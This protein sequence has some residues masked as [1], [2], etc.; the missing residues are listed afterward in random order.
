MSSLKDD[1]SLILI[2][3][4]YKDGR[5]D[6]VKPLGNSIVHPDATGNHDGTDGSTP[7]E[8]NFTF[9]RGS[10][11]AAT[12]VDVNGL[13]EKG[14]E[15]LLL[16]SNQFD[17]TWVLINAPTLTSGQA[18]Y[19]GS[20]D[21]WKLEAS[22]TGSSRS[23]HQVV[24]S[25][26]V[27]VFSVYVKAG[28]TDWIRLNLSGVGNRYFDIGNGVVGG[29]GSVDGFITDVGGGWYRCSVLGNGSST[30]PYVFLA[31]DNGNLSV[32][33]GDN[34]Y[35]QDAQLEQGLVATDY[36]ETTTT[37]VSAGILE[38]M[39]RLDYSGGASCPSLLLEPQRSNLITQSE[40]FDAWSKLN[41]GTGSNP[42]LDFGY[43]SP[44][45]KDNAY[46]VTFD[47][48]VGTTASDLSILQTS[49]TSG[50]NTASFYVKADAATRLMV[51]N[52]GTWAIY[53]IG[54]EWT[55]I[56]K[57]D[58]GGSLQIGLREGYGLSDVPDSCSVYLYGAQVEEASYPTSY[59]PTYGTSQTRSR[60]QADNQSLNP[61]LG[62]GNISVMYD[63]VYDVVG[64]EGSGQIFLL[65]SGN[66]SL[67][68]KGTQ[69]TDRRMQLFSYGDF[70]GTIGFNEDVPYQ[71]RHKVVF[72]VT[73][74]VVELFYN[75]VKQSATIS[76]AALGGVYNWSRIK[77]DP[78][79]AF[80][81]GLNQL[82]VFP[83]ALTDSECIA[84]T[85]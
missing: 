73:G 29:S 36:I 68:I 75:G 77:L 69:S 50:S 37:S 70:S 66:N 42:V 3:S 80:L 47:K 27:Q 61:V 82:L 31:S 76:G 35:I 23:I 43:T 19:D 14:R 10:N 40:Y 8:G 9:S 58:T 18:G 33:A 83:T 32:N 6:T 5:L 26:G 72:R 25:S 24:S 81:A 46:K 39:P 48:G 51:R 54:T 71:T 78:T 74:E 62:N 65:Y 64:R 20:N 67:G 7:P 28:T 53:D 13:I 34:I 57:T 17:T 84:L 2:P 49:F 56:E 79:N 41:G 55:R 21:A 59:I 44:E 15:N 12:R 38:D 4:L 1:A 45:G 11:L 63:F 30:A 22:T 60:D 52:S 16:Q 85:S